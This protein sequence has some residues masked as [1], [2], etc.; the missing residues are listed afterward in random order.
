MRLGLEIELRRLAAAP[1]FDVVVGVAADGHGFVRDV[2][3]AGQ[4]LAKLARR[5]VF[6][7][8]SS[9]AISSPIARTC[10]CRSVVS[11][12]SR[13]SLP[14]SA[15]SALRARLQLFGFG[16]G[17]AALLVELAELIQI[18]RLAARG[19]AFRNPVEVGPEV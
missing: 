3:N 8:S 15:V 13:F 7:C 19:E 16:D 1:H 11:T 5:R 9:A 14:I 6:T 18:G 10:C 4:Q 2:G 12:P 17:G